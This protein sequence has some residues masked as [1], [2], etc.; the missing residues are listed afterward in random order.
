MKS[1]LVVLVIVMACG[2]QTA[3]I[4]GSRGAFSGLAL[5]ATIEQWE[6][7]HKQAMVAAHLDEALK[8]FVAET[9]QAK[10]EELW[11]EAE[12]LQALYQDARQPGPSVS[13]APSSAIPAAFLP[14]GHRYSP[15]NRGI[16]RIY[17]RQTGRL[18]DESPVA[19]IKASSW[20]KPNPTSRYIYEV[21]PF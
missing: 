14:G 12:R 4:N 13:A 19:D 3:D 8:A 7:S 20:M 18:I 17:E 11:R 5:P 1:L 21:V 2:C 6:Y 9:D 10:K 15:N 16:M